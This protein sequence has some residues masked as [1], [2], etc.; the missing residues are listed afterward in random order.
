MKKLFF[1]SLLLGLS[2]LAYS[3]SPMEKIFESGKVIRAT[4]TAKNGINFNKG[5][6]HTYLRNGGDYLEKDQC[7]ISINSKDGGTLK[8]G[9]QIILDNLDS[10]RH[11]ERQTRCYSIFD[12][13]SSKAESSTDLGSTY[14]PAVTWIQVYDIGNSRGISIGNLNRLCKGLKFERVT[15]SK[16][17]L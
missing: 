1:T 10:D 13:D 11:W 8:K 15:L 16:K 2:T 6:Y 14:D 7:S 17:E 12:C 3:D 4:V 9:R 5:S